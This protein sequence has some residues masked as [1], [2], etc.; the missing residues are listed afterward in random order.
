MLVGHSIG[1]TY[2][3][4]YAARYPGQVAGMVLLDSSSPEQFTKIP[5]YP[6]QYAVLHRVMA[7]APTLSRLGLGRVVA[8]VAPSNLPAPAADQVRALTA[9]AHGARNT[10]DDW[11]ILHKV[12]GQAQALTSFGS[13]PLAVLTATESLQG[14]GGWA[15]ARTSSPRCPATDCTRSSTPPTWG[16]TKTRSPPPERRTPSTTSSPRS[17]PASS[18]RADNEAWLHDRV[19]SGGALRLD[20]GRSRRATRADVIPLRWGTRTRFR[21]LAADLRRPG[22]SDRGDAVTSW[23]TSNRWIVQRR[24]LHALSYCTL[25]PGPE[26]QQLAIYI[27]WLLNGLRGGLIAGTLFVLPGVVALLGR[28]RST[29][30]RATRRWSRCCPRRP[31]RRPVLAIVAQAVV[32]VGGRALGHPALVA[33]AVVAFVALWVFAVLFPVVI[34]AAAVDRLVAGPLGA[35]DHADRAGTRGGVSRC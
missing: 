27:G 26:A 30:A 31:R 21:D 33:L 10:R 25:L 35:A 12:F 28:P 8:A 23:P 32:R 16:W 2:A 5:S 14:T 17:A 19:D 1:G 24:F 22:R 6:G 18:R 29:S 20:E 4:T 7:L 34:A 9:S 11:S 3:L 15:A 13:H